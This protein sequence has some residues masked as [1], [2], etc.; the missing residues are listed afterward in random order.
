MEKKA[1]MADWIQEKV[2]PLISKFII[3]H[4]TH[5]S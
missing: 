4:L 3:D 1:S 2:V 5:V